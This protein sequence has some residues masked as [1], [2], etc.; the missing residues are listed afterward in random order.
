MFDLCIIV[1]HV[2]MYLKVKVRFKT[3]VPYFHIDENPAKKV[4]YNK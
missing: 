1:Y 3:T 2:F 4:V